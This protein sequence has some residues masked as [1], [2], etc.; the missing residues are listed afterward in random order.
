[1]DRDCRGLVVSVHDV[2]TQNWRRVDEML[3]DLA[4]WG[5]SRT[6]LLVI[7]DH[8]GR[9]RISLDSEFGEWLRRRVADGHEAVAHG[10][11]HRRERKAGDGF[12]KRMT[13]ESYTAGEGE[14][15]DLDEGEAAEALARGREEFAAVGLRPEGF[16]APAWLLG[17]EAERAVR[18]AGFRY[19]TRI[20]TV[21]DFEAERIYQSR[22]LVWSVRAGWRRATS[23]VWNEGLSLRLEAGSAPLVRVGLHPP[24]WDFR[25]IRGHVRHC[26]ER[27]RRTRGAMTYAEWVDAAGRMP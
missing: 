13:T 12:V 26:V 10:Y 21:E 19:T 22:S 15:L 23:L 24:D 3:R 14:F 2:S 17:E 4:E 6:S 8:H 11:L 5:V 9:G 1:M 25:E 7:P 16:I 27:A 20:G 18:A